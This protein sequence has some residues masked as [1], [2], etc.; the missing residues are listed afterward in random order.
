MSSWQKWPNADVPNFQTIVSSVYQCLMDLGARV[1]SIMAI[2]LKM[3]SCADFCTS[4][5]EMLQGTF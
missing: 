1:L 4:Q 3:V 2:G 5:L